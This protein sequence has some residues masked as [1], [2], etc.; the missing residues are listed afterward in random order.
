MSHVGIQRF[1]AGQ[2]QH[3][4]AQCEKAE[5][6]IRQ[7]E[8]H[9]VHGVQRP[10]DMWLMQN[11]QYPQQSQRAE[12]HTHDRTEQG[13]DTGGAFTLEGEQHHEDDY[14]QWN[15][16]RFER[17]GRHFQSFNGGKYRNGGRD[18]TIAIEQGRPRD[19][20]QHDSDARAR[21]LDLTQRQGHERDNAAFAA[22]V[23]THDEDD[24]LD[25]HHDHQ[26]PKYQ[27]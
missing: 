16:K 13:A 12:P 15:H 19:A 1:R 6:R 8:R 5:P 23:G 26:R 3:D 9:A 24:I 27:R 21:V 14:R 10:H 4:A 22:V 2:C 17:G 25:R 7:H 20:R 11:I 18:H